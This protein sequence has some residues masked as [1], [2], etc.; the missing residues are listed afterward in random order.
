LVQLTV[1]MT[2]IFTRF[3]QRGAILLLALGTI[4]PLAG[5]APGGEIDP[6]RDATVVAVERV[7]PCVVN[8]A[9]ET[10]INI[11]DP[12]EDILQRYFNVYRNKEANQPDSLGSGV[13]IDEAGYVLT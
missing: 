13:I 12:F 5:A 2:K 4:L 9:T 8:I 10:I 3:N 1:N 11:R 6:R 7:M